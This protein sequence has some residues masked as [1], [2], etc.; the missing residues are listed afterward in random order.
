MTLATELSKEEYQTGTYQERYALLMSKTQNVLGKIRGDK[1]KLLQSFIG[2]ID[3]R[4]RLAN[5]T[6]PIM[7]QAAASIQEAIHPSYLAAED[8]FSINLADPQVAGLLNGAQAC[9][10]LAPQEVGYLMNLATYPKQLWEGTKLSDVVAHFAPEAF[11][12][13]DWTELDP[14]ASRKLRLRLNSATPEPTSVIVEM[15]E[16]D[17]EWTDWFY[18]TAVHGV[19]QVRGYI[20]DVPSNGM[21]RQFRWKGGV[22]KIDGTVTAV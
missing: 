15:R 12:G 20:F 9:G 21:S 5:A 19:F 7:V 14:G 22:Y 10:L 17:G 11:I 3:L 13:N 18:V 1:I 8:T 16:F 4:N 6:D 2:A